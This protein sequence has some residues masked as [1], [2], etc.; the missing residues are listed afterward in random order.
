MRVRE[1][2]ELS[3]VHLNFRK[4]QVPGGAGVLFG[5]KGGARACSVH[6]RLRKRWQ[7]QRNVARGE[8]A[9]RPVSPRP[10]TDLS[11]PFYISYVLRLILTLHLASKFYVMISDQNNLSTY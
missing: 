2:A 4:E 8:L 5:A 11:G 6:S 7:S 9:A 1:P 10:G 3:R